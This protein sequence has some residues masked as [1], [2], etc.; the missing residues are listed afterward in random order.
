MSLTAIAFWVVLLLLAGYAVV[1]YNGLVRLKHAVGKA[2]ANIDVL[3]KQRHDEL[4]KLVEACK[5]YMQH[6]RA[7]LE[8]VIAARNAVAS[9]RERADVNALGKAESGLRAGLGQLFALAENYPQL[10]AN[11]SF[12]FLSQR[13]SG[14]ENGSPIAASCTTRR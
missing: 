10:K 2:W 12:Q 4:P 8:R 13:I 14:L 11:E 6:E 1:L 7:T 5:Q 3:L 9:A